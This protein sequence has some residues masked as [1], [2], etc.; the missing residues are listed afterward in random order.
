M[1][2]S[3]TGGRSVERAAAV[4]QFQPRGACAVAARAAAPGVELLG[5]KLDRVSV[6]LQGLEQQ[7]STLRAQLD[8]EAYVIGREFTV[9]DGPQD[10]KTIPWHR[11]STG[12]LIGTLA[13]RLFLEPPYLL[14]LRGKRI[15]LRLQRIA[16][17][18]YGS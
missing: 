13:V 3:S 16:F 2:D 4:E 11:I 5:V 6:A 10:S 12:A 18:R 1:R 15:A 9:G 8:R 14:Y 17:R 7:E